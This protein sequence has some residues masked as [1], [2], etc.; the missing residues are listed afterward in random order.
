MPALTL[1]SAAPS[2]ERFLRAT[3][4]S[5][6]TIDTYLDALTKFTSYTDEAG[7]P[8]AVDAIRRRH[9]EGWIVAMQEAGNAPAS[10]SVRYRALR[11]FFNWLVEDDE[12]ESAPTDRLKIPKP[13]VH[14][15]PVL[16]DADI[17]ALLGTTTGRDFA[18]RRDAAILRLLLDTGMRRGE[19]AGL[20]VAD[21]DLDDTV[22]IVT[23]KGG[24]R[25][26]AWFGAKTARAL[27]RYLRVR[28]DH[29]HTHDR[30]LWLGER[31]PLQANSILQVVRRRAKQAG[32]GRVFTHMF[33]HTYAHRWLASGGAEGDLM[34]I[35]GWTTRDMLSRYGASA[36]AERARDA[37]KRL[38][39]GDR[40]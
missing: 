10:V 38:A 12:I 34:Q 7:H 13:K 22:V 35:A 40:Y 6:R 29:P 8:T 14:P 4:K 17:R 18:S 1:T 5:Q 28:A 9:I 27:D 36:A 24:R 11:A 19:L 3:G 32:L 20:A 30:A 2:F 15:P 21:V 26:V 37:H 31:G 39:L 33:R 23:G 25:R 16:T